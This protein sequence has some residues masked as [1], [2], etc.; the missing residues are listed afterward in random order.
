MEGASVVSEANLS[1]TSHF[2]LFVLSCSF[3]R[4]YHTI[5]YKIL[6]FVAPIL[7][8]LSVILE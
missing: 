4:Y 2:N 5:Q 7:F 1:M 3:S 6:R 8:S